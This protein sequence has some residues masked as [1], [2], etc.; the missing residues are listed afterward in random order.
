MII[1][2]RRP[3]R[4]SPDDYPVRAVGSASRGEG[5]GF[6]NTTFLSTDI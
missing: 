5:Y 1:S 6:A 3:P 4:P 2:P